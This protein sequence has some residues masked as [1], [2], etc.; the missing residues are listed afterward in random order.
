MKFD[1]RKQGHVTIL[2]LQGEVTGDELSPVRDLLDIQ[3]QE[4]GCDLVFDLTETEF[5]DSKGLEL[6][7]WAQEQANENLGQVRLVGA[8]EVVQQVLHMTR[9]A[10]RFE[11]HPDLEEAMVSLR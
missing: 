5:V 1:S 11:A 2:K 6:L 7:L 10:G 9:L 8:N 3:L 4:H